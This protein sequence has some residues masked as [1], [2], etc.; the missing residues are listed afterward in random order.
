MIFVKTFIRSLIRGVTQGHGILSQI[1]LKLGSVHFYY[2]YGELFFTKYRSSQFYNISMFNFHS[3]L[4]YNA[5]NRNL[6]GKWTK[7]R[8]W[9]VFRPF[10]TNLLKTRSLHIHLPRNTRYLQE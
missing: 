1:L 5:A 10:R 2:N 3:V 8:P 6:L 4:R 9:I 7:C